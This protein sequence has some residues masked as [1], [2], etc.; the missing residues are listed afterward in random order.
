M[1]RH[2]DGEDATPTAGPAPERAGRPPTLTERVSRAA[3][4][5]HRAAQSGAPVAPPAPDNDAASIQAL[6]SIV[7]RALVLVGLVVLVLGG[8]VGVYLSVPGLGRAVPAA[9]PSSPPAASPVA[10]GVP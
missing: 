3:V 5:A 6:A 10:P 4:A 8:M 9:P 1:A 2:P 7:N